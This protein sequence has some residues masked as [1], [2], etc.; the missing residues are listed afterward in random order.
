[1]AIGWAMCYGHRPARNLVRR[2]GWSVC[3]GAVRGSAGGLSE[4]GADGGL[5]CGRAG[6]AGWAVWG[7]EDGPA[8]FLAPPV[9]EPADVNGAVADRVQERGDRRLGVGVVT[10]DREKGAIGRPGGAASC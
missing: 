2:A 1:M 6:G 7:D 9:G 8:D 5:A 4:R 10:G 3:R